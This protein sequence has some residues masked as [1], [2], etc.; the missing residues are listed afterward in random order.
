MWQSLLY[1]VVQAFD[2]IANLFSPSHIQ[3]AP[4]ERLLL[5]NRLL[6]YVCLI[7][8]FFSLL[9][10]CV[11]LAINFQIGVWLMLSCFVLIYLVLIYFR[12]TG[13]Y[14]LSAN[15]Y[16]AC[17][18]VVAVL[19]CSAF[20]GGIHS[21]V[22]PWFSLIPIAS[23]LLLGYCPST[24]FWFL[25][26]IGLTISYGVAVALGYTFPELFH[27]EHL[28]FFYTTCVAGLVMILFFIAL[29][30]DHNRILALRKIIEQK[31]AL[32][33]ARNQAEVATQ[34]KSRFLAIM[35]H[36]IK[37]PMTSIVGYS[38][39]LHSTELNEKQ[40]AYLSHIESASSSLLRIIDDIL[41][42]SKI[43][44]GKL[45]FES[46][47][48][49][50]KEVVDNVVK[51]VVVEADKK[52]IELVVSVG[53]MVPKR[54]IGDSL[55]LTQALGNLV[56]NAVKFTDSGSVMIEVELLES[57]S[58][59]CKLR[60]DVVDTGIGISKEHLS[61]MFDAFNQADTSITRRFGGTG[62][63]LAITKHLVDM[64]QGEVDVKS[65]PGQG[66]QFSF[67]C[68]FQCGEQLS[69][70]PACDPYKLPTEYHSA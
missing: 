59:Y 64:M 40:R 18:C 63:G 52:G 41:D 68:R 5:S 7:T 19:G 62:L 21:M 60:F 35:S 17:C 15:L 14:Q 56:S 6:V 31:D 53:S 46:V 49:D 23:I 44:A 2:W 22:Y 8:S 29:V 39:I 47:E 32:E 20:S 42:I 26:S 3:V 54:L 69:K 11:S 12:K 38:E 65:A 37:T 10:V 24:L 16:L 33:L 67:T 28:N 43:E 70:T 25:F 30:F 34:A 1:K 50:L 57:D 48:F 36:E 4:D 61:G 51:M 13:H 45:F 27:L 55:R 58:F 9:Y 66:S